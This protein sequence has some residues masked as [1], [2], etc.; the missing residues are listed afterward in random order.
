MCDNVSVLISLNCA[1]R[2]GSDGKFCVC[3]VLHTHAHRYTHTRTLSWAL[4]LSALPHQAAL[5]LVLVV[6]TVDILMF[7]LE[8]CLFSQFPSDI[9]YYFN[10]QRRREGHLKNVQENKKVREEFPGG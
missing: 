5:R 7:F 10:N 8:P 4:P 9:I 6:E 1:L 3:I 2:T